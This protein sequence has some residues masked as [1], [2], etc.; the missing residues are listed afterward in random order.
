M[1]SASRTTRNF[2]QGKAAFIARSWVCPGIPQRVLGPIIGF[3]SLLPSKDEAR[4][5]GFIIGFR[6]QGSG[7]SGLGY[8]K[9]LR[10]P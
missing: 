1:G 9:G 4:I 8:F 5:A 7:F 6:V 3:F 10:D 2:S